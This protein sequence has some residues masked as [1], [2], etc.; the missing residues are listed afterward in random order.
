[1]CHKLRSPAP[2]RIHSTGNRIINIHNHNQ[3]FV[4]VAIDRG[5]GFIHWN[6]I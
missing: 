2:I 1:M 4:V 3:M 5:R 6:I